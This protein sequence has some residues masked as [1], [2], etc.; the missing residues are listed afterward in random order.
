MT[1]STSPPQRGISLLNDIP[2]ERTCADADVAPHWCT[3]FQWRSVA[4]DDVNVHQAA[5]DVVAANNRMTASRRDKCVRLSLD[6]VQAAEMYAVYERLLL[7]QRSADIHG[8]IPEMLTRLQ[9]AI[10]RNGKEVLYRATVKTMPGGALYEATVRMTVEDRKFDVDTRQIS[11]V[12]AY[13]EQSHCVADMVPH[14][15]AYCYCTEQ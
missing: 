6:G 5:L 8:R 1:S 10:N 3:C 9:V 15:R 13:G 12:N 14:L 2:A 4:V 7:F 11:R